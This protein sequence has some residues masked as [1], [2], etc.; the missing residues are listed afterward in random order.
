IG[1]HLVEVFL[2][3]GENFFN[4]AHL[5]SQ[6]LDLAGDGAVFIGSSRRRFRRLRVPGA[7][8]IQA[9]A[10]SSERLQGKVGNGRGHYHADEDYRSG[11]QQRTPHPFLHL[12]F[13]KDGR[14]AD[15]NFAK[16]F[17]VAKQRQPHIV[18]LGRAVDDLELLADAAVDD[19]GELLA[20]RQDFS[21][22]RRIA[23]QKRL[24]PG[25]SYGCVINGGR[26]AD[27]GIEQR[28]QLGIGLQYLLHRRRH[29]V[30]I[31]QVDLGVGQIDGQRVTSHGKYLI[32]N[33]KAAVVSLLDALV[34]NLGD[35]KRGERSHNRG[36]QPG[37]GRYQ[38]GFE[39]QRRHSLLSVVSKIDSK[40]DSNW[41]LRPKSLRRSRTL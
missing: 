6:P 37:N 14:D 18:D 38:F 29:L 40:T 10:D 9:A 24:A 25:V 4:V 1:H 30:G 34:H 13:Q 32:A 16:R 23:V 5:P 2:Q 31:V 27:G 21:E 39:A 20:R 22:V 33:Q 36:H 15:T 12:V 19:G 35:V 17:S 11:N 8:Q 7:D 41:P 28:I 26:V 3:G